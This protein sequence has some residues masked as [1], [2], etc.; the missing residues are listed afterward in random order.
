MV[1]PS[2]KKTPQCTASAIF[3]WI[4]GEAWP[5]CA[6]ALLTIT[7]SGCGTP[8]APQ[9]P[10]LGLPEPVTDLTAVR[11][12]NQ[13]TLHWKMP[14][15]STDRLPLKST[16]TA[17]LCR[18]IGSAPLGP[19]TTGSGLSA[20]QNAGAVF[21]T[22]G[23]PAEFHETL[24]A[25]LIAGS[26]R[27]LT[28]YLELKNRSGHSAGLS[29]AATVLAGAAPAPITGLTAAPRA[30]GIAL[31][32][33]SDES[34]MSVRIHRELIHAK[35]VAK[36]AGGSTGALQAAPEPTVRDF[37]VETPAQSG[38]SEAALDGSAG[39]DATYRYTVQRIARITV[40]GRQLEL[41][42][43][44]AAPVEIHFADDFPPAVPSGLA[45]VYVPEGKTIDLSW[46]PDSEED[47]AGYIVYRAE[48]DEAWQR[49]SPAQ[50]VAS[51]AYRDAA[52][53][54]GHSYK[55]AVSA[56]DETGHE[57]KRSEP[58]EESAPES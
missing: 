32:W 57:S 11:A 58:A 6:A 3:R 47:L 30:D 5:V 54:P 29:N 8:G 36:P 22:L 4:S 35:L 9:P 20:C 56:I 49:V 24:P 46:Q 42:G 51:P 52:V 23:T 31:H 39:F 13:V 15:K 26:P 41:A 55:Y 7:L 14:K 19:N 34:H 18:R 40:D 33:L 44:A 28:Y 25:D 45:A 16:V 43:Q 1:F 2:R 12:G 53:T 37:F 38:T 50:P 10:S 48:G 21:P 27:Q 17:L